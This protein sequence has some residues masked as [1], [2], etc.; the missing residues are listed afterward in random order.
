MLMHL[1][2]IEDIDCVRGPFTVGT[3]ASRRC[4][5]DVAKGLDGLDDEGRAQGHMDAGEMPIDWTPYPHKYGYTNR[6][7]TWL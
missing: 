4:L 6:V 1:G 3:A 7:T 2:E 5:Y